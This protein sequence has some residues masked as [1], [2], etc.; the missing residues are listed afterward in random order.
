M[1][2]SLF[3]CVAAHSTMHASVDSWVTTCERLVDEAVERDLPATAFVDSLKNLEHR[4]IKAIDYIEE[5]NQH[6][7]I[8]R[9]K[10]KQSES[11]QQESSE[12]LP[13]RAQT[14]DDRDKAVENYHTLDFR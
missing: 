9:S 3:V 6:V 11:P 10:T 12:G 8:R 14:Q 2:P 13:A 4:A 1:G 7:A 5:F